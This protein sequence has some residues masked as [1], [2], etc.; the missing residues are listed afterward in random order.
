MSEVKEVATEEVEPLLI[1]NGLDEFLPVLM[2][3]HEKQV[4]IVE[5]LRMVPVGIEVEIEGS[6]PFTLTAESHRAF[7][8]GIELSLQYLGSLPFQAEYE[9]EPTLQ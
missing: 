1:V 8:M 2:D 4:A 7:Q 6:A 9:E 5:H 3:W